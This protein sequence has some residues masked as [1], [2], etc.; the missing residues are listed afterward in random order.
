MQRCGSTCG[1]VDLRVVAR[2]VCSG[3]DLRVSAERRATGWICAWLSERRAVLRIYA[4]RCK[5]RAAVHLTLSRPTA[6]LPAGNPFI[7][8]IPKCSSSSSQDSPLLI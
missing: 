2:T 5:R 4:G 3:A 7:R 6:Q 1:G 8:Q